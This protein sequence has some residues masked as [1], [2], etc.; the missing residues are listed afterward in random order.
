[1]SLF[2]YTSMR[3]APANRHRL[4]ML[5]QPVAT[6]EHNYWP[7]LTLASTGRLVNNNKLDV[8]LLFPRG[9]NEWLEIFHGRNFSSR[10]IKA[11]ATSTAVMA[12]FLQRYHTPKTTL[13]FSGHGVGDALHK[14][15]KH[16]LSIENFAKVLGPNYYRCILFDSCYMANTA[17]V[18]HLRNHTRWIGASEGAVWTEPAD[19][20]QYILTPPL[21][22]QLPSCEPLMFMRLVQASFHD[23]QSQGDFSILDTTGI[24]KI[25]RLKLKHRTPPID[26]EMRHLF[27]LHHALGKRDR[28]KLKAVVRQYAPPPEGLYKTEHHGLS[29]SSR[30]RLHRF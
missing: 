10:T 8:A 5:C 20:A 15:K 9:R 19:A 22:S 17:T 30:S 28:G 21:I 27:D 4:L 25:I 24:E 18:Y 11:P 3:C 13:Y 6:F 16:R 2:S 7:W 14:T 12:D 23:R 26:P 1:M 29:F